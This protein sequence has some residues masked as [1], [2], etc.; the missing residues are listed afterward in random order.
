MQINLSIRKSIKTNYHAK[1]ALNA[2][3]LFGFSFRDITNRSNFL[4]DVYKTAAISVKVG[5]RSWN[6]R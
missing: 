2:N 1:I 6:C 4:F 5:V 3:R